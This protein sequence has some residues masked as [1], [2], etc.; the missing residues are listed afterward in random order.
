[1]T[2]DDLGQSQCVGQRCGEKSMGLDSAVK[3]KQRRASVAHAV[4][5]MLRRNVAFLQQLNMQLRLTC[6]IPMSMSRR[7][8]L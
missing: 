5:H 7:H 3:E 2:A 8:V 1:M 4:E 6:S